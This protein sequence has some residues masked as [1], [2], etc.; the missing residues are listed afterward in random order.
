MKP[1]ASLDPLDSRIEPDCLRR[2][3]RPFSSGARRSRAPLVVRGRRRCG[4]WA[5]GVRARHDLR[6][7]R[8]DR[9]VRQLTRPAIGAP[10]ANSGHPEPEG[11]ELGAA[12][13]APADG[14]WEQPERRARPWPEAGRGSAPRRPSDL[15]TGVAPFY[16]PPACVP[17]S[18]RTSRV[19]VGNLWRGSDQPTARVVGLIGDHAARVAGA[20]A[21]GIS[22]MTS[23]VHQCSPP[24]H[25][26][27][28]TVSP[29]SLPPRR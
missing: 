10:P 13:R 12:I 5:A 21:P 14:T 24:T 22:S 19:R 23:E 28:F 2:L 7:L 4:G 18:P 1:A 11:C 9:R 20:R 29:A 3:H 17:H 25:G 16:R 8:P 26:A 15:L 27:R 6:A